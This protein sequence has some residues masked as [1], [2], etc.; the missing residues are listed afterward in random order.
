MGWRWRN[1]IV[2]GVSGESGFPQDLLSAAQ[3]PCAQDQGAQHGRIFCS[4]GEFS[5]GAVRQDLGPSSHLCLCQGPEHSTAL[6]QGWFLG[7]IV[8]PAPSA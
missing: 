2:A 5:S 1:R 4:A 3:M 6:I 7:Q 8:Q